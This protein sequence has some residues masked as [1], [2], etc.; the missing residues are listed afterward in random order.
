MRFHITSK[1]FTASCTLH[2]AL[3]AMITGHTGK[4]VE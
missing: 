2:F 3:K 4:K 1:A